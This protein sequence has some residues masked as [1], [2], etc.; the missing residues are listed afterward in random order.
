MNIVKRSLYLCIGVLLV[1]LAVQGAQSL[2]Q[3]SRLSAASEAIVRSGGAADVA[4]QLWTQFVRTEAAFERAVAFVDAAGIA[5]RRGAYEATAD[6]LGEWVERLPADAAAGGTE[7]AAVREQVNAWLALASPHVLGGA[8]TALPSPH[9]LASA[10]ATLEARVDALVE[11]ASVA[12]ADAVEAAR[13]TARRAYVWTS[14]ELGAAVC[15]GLLLGG[16]ALRN[17]RRQLGADAGEVATITNSIAAGDLSGPA[18]DAGLPPASIMSATIR[19]KRSLVETVS[20]VHAISARVSGGADA[21]AAGSLALSES[22]RKQ[23]DAMRETTE[24]MEALGAKVERNARSTARASELAGHA[25]AVATEGGQIAGQVIATMSDI[26]QSAQ[27]IADITGVI[28]GIAFQTNLLALNAAV[29]AARAGE[30][31]KGFAVVAS[32]VRNLAKASA[33]AAHDIKA[34]IDSS[35][36]RVR[37]G[38]ELVDRSG[39]T[40]QQV[41]EEIGQVALLMRE[42]DEGTGEQTRGLEQVRALVEKVDGWTRRDAEG[43]DEGARSAEELREQSVRL[44][45]AVAFFRL[46]AGRAATAR[47][48]A[49]RRAA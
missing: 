29:E 8:S 21:I 47:D 28:D 35:L 15:L 4:R 3:V 36:E 11:A 27:E 10:R 17:L 6:A 45:D 22:A 39:E 48:E 31:G 44:I 23:A 30:H 24:T 43:A 32:E 42:I 1:L 16:F 9:R 26:S 18:D 40:M 37:L 33:D 5:E 38:S 2:L 25:N 20:N 41:V 13:A 34:L 46:D 12:A 19:M 14:V 7:A 49:P